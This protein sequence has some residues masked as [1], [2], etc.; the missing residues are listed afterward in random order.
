MSITPVAST[1]YRPFFQAA[2]APVKMIYAI[3][4]KA[5]GYLLLFLGAKEWGENLKMK[6]HQID[7][8]CASIFVGI[9]AYGTRFLVHGDNSEKSC[10]GS[11][12]WIIDQHFANPEK[13]LTE[14]ALEFEDGAPPAAIQMAKDNL[15]PAD[16]LERRVW[17]ETTPGG[18]PPMPELDPGVYMF[19]IGYSKDAN[20]HGDAHLF[21]LFRQE[22]SM[23][24][25]PD[26]GLSEWHNSDWKPLLDR[27]GSELRSSK[28]GYFTLECHSCRKVSH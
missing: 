6:G 27:I 5:L 16:L 1:Y 14:L 17:S 25:D 2:I 10:R 9:W 15:R 26:T 28:G 13:P 23:L 8:Q 7:S 20:S 21:A 12:Y 11:C 4:L 22:K 24:F 3:F 19:L 18:W